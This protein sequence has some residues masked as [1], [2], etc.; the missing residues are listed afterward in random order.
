MGIQM[1]PLLHKLINELSI[2]ELRIQQINE[3]VNQ[4]ALADEAKE[5]HKRTIKIM[6]DNSKEDV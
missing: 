1:D 6:I 3:T 2:I 5:C 4:M